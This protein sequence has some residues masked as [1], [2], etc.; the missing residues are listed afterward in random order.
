M[1]ILIDPRSTQV[2]VQNETGSRLNTLIAALVDAGYSLSYVNYDAPLAP[3]LA[4]SNLFIIITHRWACPPGWPPAI[5]ET[6]DFSWPAADLDAIQSWVNQ[7]G[8]LLL[9]STHTD[10]S[11]YDIPLA[12]KFGIKIVPAFFCLNRDTRT[13]PLIMN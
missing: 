8:S 4:A 3:Q 12:A 1:N 11:I 9:I 5:P 13:D 10:Y 6:T 2:Q 7:G